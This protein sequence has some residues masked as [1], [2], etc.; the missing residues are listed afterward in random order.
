MTPL[1][2]CLCG[3]STVG[4]LTMCLLAWASRLAICLDLLLARTHLKHFPTALQTVSVCLSVCRPVC[5]FEGPFVCL[6]VVLSF[7]LFLRVCLF[8]CLSVCSSV[9]LSVRQPSFPCTH[10]CVCGCVWHRP[11]SSGSWSPP[12]PRIWPAASSRA[13]PWS[14]SQTSCRQALSGTTSWTVST[15]WSTPGTRTRTAS[16]LMR[17]GWAKLCSASAFLV[18]VT[19]VSVHLQ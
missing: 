19:P 5:L 18:C 12:A 16:W 15:G 7:G 17:W 11:G 14:A 10:D 3:L 8:I 6:P 9:C 13:E 4:S 1:N 2:V